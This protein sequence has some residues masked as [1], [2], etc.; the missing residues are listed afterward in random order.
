VDRWDEL[1][2]QPN[3]DVWSSPRV[4]VC[5]GKSVL[6]TGAGGYIG[7]AL[8]KAI[9]I[10]DPRLLI[11]IDHTEE[12]LYRI[13]NE[14]ETRFPATAHVS[15]LGDI[16]DGALLSEI[17]HTYHPHTVFHAAAYKHVSLLE[18]NPFPATSNNVLGTLALAQT[19]L[20]HEAA[21]L[22]MVSTDKAVNPAS[23]MGA[24]KRIAELVLLS[25]S[26]TKTR[27]SAVRFGNV[28]GS[29]GSVV[30]RFIRQIAEHGP[31]TVT[32]RD[33]SRYFLTLPEAVELILAAASLDENGS[34]LI[35]RMPPPI[36][37]LDL[38]NRLVNAYSAE[39]KQPIEIIFTGLRP[40]EKLTEQIVSSRESVHPTPEPSLH[41]VFTPQIPADVLDAALRKLAVGIQERNFALL[42]DTVSTLVPEYCPSES[43][44]GLL[45]AEL[46]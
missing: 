23:V 14:L 30:P 37:I 10:S 28:F 43:V 17:F 26:N 21:R 4:S 24:S 29:T 46:A 11:L 2:C 15:I 45:K 38:A 3:A 5:A 42:F 13:Q 31:L 39:S 35:P 36:N 9:A 25:L 7:S 12:N 18:A 34:I 27:M 22:V 40:G 16:G 44:L 20:Q 33:A 1:L 41:R 19:C 32:H 6:I 8:A